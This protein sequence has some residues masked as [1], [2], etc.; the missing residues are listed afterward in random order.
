MEFPSFAW[1]AHDNFWYIGLSLLL[2]KNYFSF[3]FSFFQPMSLIDEC[4]Y[5]IVKSSSNLVIDLCFHTIVFRNTPLYD[6]RLWHL[7][8]NGPAEGLFGNVLWTQSSVG[9]MRLSNVTFCTHGSIISS[10]CL[11]PYIHFP[12]FLLISDAEMLKLPLRLLTFSPLCL[13]VLPHVD[14][15]S[16]IKFEVLWLN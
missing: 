12:P 6:S 4:F 15:S 8:T 10:D 13:S 7:V 2:P 3:S 16:V 5:N 1:P 11:L 14:W 9:I